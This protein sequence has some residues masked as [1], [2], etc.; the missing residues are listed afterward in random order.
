M[1]VQLHLSNH[2]RSLLEQ[3]SSIL[4]KHFGAAIDADVHLSD[5]EQLPAALA[6]RV[7]SA[8]DYF[9]GRPIGLAQLL[10]ELDLAGVHGALCW[11]NPSA[12]EYGDDP[13]ENH[14][15]LLDANRYVAFAADE[16][17]ERILPAGWTDPKALGVEGAVALVDALVSELGFPIVKLNPAQNA[18][19]I[20]GHD[21]LTVVRRILAWG[22]VPAFH[23]GA[24]TPYTPASG[25][26]AVA[27]LC[28][29]Q[30]V[31]AVHMGGGGASYTAAEELYH[32]TRA[33]GLRRK[34]IHFILSSRRDSHTVSDLIAFQ[35]A[36]NPSC[37][38][39]SWGSDAPY[40]SI[41][42]NF[43]GIEA[44]LRAMRHRNFPDPRIQDN[45]ALFDDEAVRDYLGGNI[46][47]LY[48]EAC[49][50]VLATATYR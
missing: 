43:G 10:G 18:F 17:P 9:H 33:L 47:R 13:V 24:D 28:D 39:L 25:L 2:A 41:P 36:G 45:P 7:Q 22:A 23:Y 48:G 21:S 3:R 50:S 32:E 38:N 26:E 11:Q 37:A 16:E 1:A 34:N 44:L 19:P 49:S 5:P 12:T 30:P 35:E 8:P 27:E 14:R 29:P 31:I 40:G 20:D 6:E 42:W 4:Q 15:R 46:A